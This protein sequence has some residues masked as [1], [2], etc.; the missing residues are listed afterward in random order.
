MSD[1]VGD[2]LGL[3]AICR[4]FAKKVHAR[5]RKG[6]RLAREVAN[7]VRQ[8]VPFSVG[9]SHDDCSMALLPRPALVS[10]PPRRRMRKG[11]AV[12][13][14]CPQEFSMFLALGVEWSVIITCVD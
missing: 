11:R 1:G 12:D 6:S 5:H 13:R 10:S 14:A 3:Q 4:N 7:M 9:P 8:K 2:V